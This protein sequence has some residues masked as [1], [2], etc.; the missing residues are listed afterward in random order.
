MALALARSFGV[1]PMC[2]AMAVFGAND[3]YMF[4][5]NWAGATLRHDWLVLL[6]FAACALKAQR[7]VLA[8]VLLAVATHVARVAGRGAGG[9]GDTGGGLGRRAAGGA[10][11][12]SAAGRRCCASTG[13]RCARWWRR[14]RPCVVAFLITGFVYGFAAWGE[15]WQKIVLLNRDSSV[16]EVSLRALVAGA[17]AAQARL[18]A[19]RLG[20]FIPAAIGCVAAIV[21][22]ARRRPLHEAMLLG[23]A[24][25][26]GDP[27][28]GQLPPAL[29]VLAGAGADVARHQRHRRAAAVDVRRPAT[30]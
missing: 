28:P 2:V 23:A 25:G 8:G 6:A 26:A 4:G 19:A 9:R 5:T 7:W 30:G 16:N 18:F 17:D 3:L 11:P 29:R 22:A 21:W 24:A 20:I 14:R 27:A 10:T 1:L 15:W 12:A 13:T